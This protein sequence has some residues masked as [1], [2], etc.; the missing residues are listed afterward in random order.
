MTKVYFPSDQLYGIGVAGN[1]E[2]V[3][4]ANQSIVI[5]LV[6]RSG[7]IRATELYLLSNHSES[8]Y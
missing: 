3:V 1:K 8:L 2:G 6:G 5:S 4:S 7:W